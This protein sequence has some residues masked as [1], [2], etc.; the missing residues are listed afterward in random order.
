[1][2]GQPRRLF[3]TD[4][5][6]AITTLA[7]GRSLPRPLSEDER[8]IVAIAAIA[9]PDRH[10]TLDSPDLD[11]ADVAREWAKLKKRIVRSQTTSAPLIYCGCFSQSG[12]GGYHAHM[13]LWEFVHLNIIHGHL[14]DLRFGSAKMRR[15][16]PD[17][18]TARYAGSRVDVADLAT[19]V[20]TARMT[21]YVLGQH[22]P[23]FDWT[24]HKRHAPRE[25]NKKWLVRPHDITLQTHRP[26]LL[27]ALRAAESRSTTDVQLV[28]GLPN[29]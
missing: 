19:L 13:L 15:V 9:R 2:T 27:S 1:M 11:R 12:D 14:R 21:A 29:V 8:L 24:V 25:R 20:G 16:E 22:R 10:L 28:R 4:L 23:V 6:L 7:S 26:E 3:N 18:I 5:R 17:S